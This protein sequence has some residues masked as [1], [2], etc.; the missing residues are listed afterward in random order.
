M[1]H[2]E[3]KSAFNDGRSFAAEHFKEIEM[4]ICKGKRIVLEQVVAWLKVCVRTANSDRARGISDKD[5]LDTTIGALESMRD[6]YAEQLASSITLVSNE[7]SK[8]D[9]PA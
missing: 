9:G 6:V 8:E 3:Y 1:T 4:G 7:I 5:V 2:E